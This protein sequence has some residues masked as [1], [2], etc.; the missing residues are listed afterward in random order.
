MS[1]PDWLLHPEVGLCPC[2][3]IG[4]RRKGSYLDKTVEGG[5]SMLRGVLFADD[6]AARPGLLQRLDPRVKLLM[7]AGMLVVTA[8][9]RNVVVLLGIYAAMLALASASQVPLFRFVRRVWLFVPIF[10]GIVVLPATLNVVTPGAILVPLGTWL[11]HPLG[12]TAQGLGAAGLIVARVATSI[13]IVV[14]LAITTRW[15]DLLAALR[16]F[17]VPRLFIVVLAMAYRYVFHLLSAVIDMFTA[18]KARTVSRDGTT[19]R[20]RDFV[21]ASAG[22]LF[23]KSQALAEE[24]HMAMVARGFTG[25]ARPMSQFRIRALDVMGAG[26]AI[27]VMVATVGIDRLVFS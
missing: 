4:T 23:G 24:V 18:R 27:A 8:L 17:L 13:S 5:A 1:A 9:V 19:R 26:T 22:A 25:E 14:L 2:G 3:C 15:S 12:V 16:A 11:G 20:S 6:V 10:T 21:A 7:L